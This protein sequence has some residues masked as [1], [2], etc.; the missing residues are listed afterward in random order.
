M[1][2][3]RSELLKEKLEFHKKWLY[4]RLGD[5]ERDNTNDRS[6]NT[7]ERTY[8]SNNRT[9]S[10]PPINRKSY[11][12]IEE[13]ENHLRSEEK[14][15]LSSH[16]K[17]D[18]VSYSYKDFF[19]DKKK[20]KRW[21]T[22]YNLNKK[23]LQMKE[24]IAQKA[25]VKEQDPECTFHPRIRNSNLNKTLSNPLSMHERNK[26]WKEQKE[27]RLTVHREINKDRDLKGCTFQPDIDY[28]R[29][30][31]N[32]RGVTAYESKG[33]ERHLRRQIVAR[34][35]KK[36]KD[37][38][39]KNPLYRFSENNLKKEGK[40]TVP[41]QPNFVENAREILIPSLKK[42]LIPTSFT[43]T[44]SQNTNGVFPLKERFDN[45]TTFVNQ[46]TYD[47]HHQEVGFAN[48]LASLHLELHQFE[49]EYE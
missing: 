2:Q 32:F 33:I 27:A 44:G 37:L 25:Q 29:K 1:K 48:A 6:F 22:L 26:L 23:N 42:P 20:P 43:M 47:S 17:G 15:S 21:E 14:D 24:E 11:S 19:E 13:T 18:S 39:L 8:H 31:Q 5:N 38:I 40:L 46:Q 45:E 12:F 30:T 28:N 41:K 3:E 4:S 10:E 36:E 49:I 9:T 35:V 16:M 7:G 34:Q